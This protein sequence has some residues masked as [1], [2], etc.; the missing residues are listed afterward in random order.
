MVKFTGDVVVIYNEEGR[1]FDDVLEQIL[2]I[3][4]NSA[5]D[6]DNKWEMR[7]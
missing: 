1:S 3:V 5:R 4:V 2:K 7:L 6:G